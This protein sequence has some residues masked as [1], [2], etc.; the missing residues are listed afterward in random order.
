[1]HKNMNK[2][3]KLKKNKWGFYQ[4]KDKP[5]IEELSTYY[6]EKYF[7]HDS[8][9]YK[10]NYDEAEIKHKMLICKI[11]VH[12]AISV[13]GDN[14]TKTAY[15]VGCGE[16]FMVN[17]FNNQKFNVLSCDFSNT[18]NKYFPQY[19]KSHKQG[20]LNQIIQNDFQNEQFD[21]ITLTNV[22]EH[23][24]NPEELLSILKKGMKENSVLAIT[25][26]NDFSE[27]QNF[28]LEKK[29]TNPRWI[30]YPDHLNYFNK[31]S[32]KNF[33]ED[34]GL[35]IISSLASFPIEL[36]LLNDVLNYDKN[37][38]V[39][40]SVY[41]IIRDFELYISQDFNKIMK[42]YEVYAE[43]DIGRNIT[44]YCKLKTN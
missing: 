24:L 14:S 4:F 12:K 22:L 40:R 7:T 36:F 3:D 15:D 41:S 9:S 44:Y 2:V 38:E 23:T 5:S 18:I 33:L 39:S 32:M 21:I 16:G 31:T 25:V 13:L 19:E 43:L 6:K 17:E 1:M 34:H 10:V 42:L 37:K 28:L 11:L 8:G 35:T 30:C 26:P 20:D 29:Q 27:L